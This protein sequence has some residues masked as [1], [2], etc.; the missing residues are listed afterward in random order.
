MIISF[1]EFPLK[2]QCSCDNIA[3]EWKSIM[4]VGLLYCSCDVIS[5]YLRVLFVSFVYP[6][7]DQRPIYRTVNTKGCFH[8][9]RKNNRG[10]I[11]KRKDFDD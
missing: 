2:T 1:H 4:S 7:K 6:F 9:G 5:V 8:K 10:T 11:N 3:V